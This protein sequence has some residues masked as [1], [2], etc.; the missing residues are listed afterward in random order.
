[1]TL[2][3]RITQNRRTLFLFIWI[4][5][6]VLYVPAVHAGFVS[7]FTG[8]IEQLT[9]NK[10]IDYLN[11]K[12]SQITSLYQFT[13]FS[14]WV[15]YK[16]FG[17]NAW[18]WFLLYITL[19]ALNSTLLY[20][21]SNTL[22]EKADIKNADIIALTGVMLFCFCPHLT[23][24]VVYKASYHYLQ[25]FLFIL[26]IIYWLQQFQ[27][28]GSIKY[29]WW[30]AVIFFIS[31]YSLE[32]FYLTPLFTIGMALFYW[33]VLQYDK[34]VLKRSMQYFLIPQIIL[35]LLH[36]AVFHAIHGGRLPHVSKVDYPYPFYLSKPVKYLFHILL[37]GRFFPQHI[38]DAVY[39]WSESTAGLLTFY[40]FLI[41]VWALIIVRFKSFSPKAKTAVLLFIFVCFTAVLLIPLGFPPM[42][43][44]YGDRHTYLLCAFT[45]VLLALMLSYITRRYLSIAIGGIYLLINL[46]LTIQLNLYWKRS[47]YIVNRLLATFPAADNKTVVLLDL[48]DNMKGVP[49]LYESLY[50]ALHNAT[51][52]DKI[53][54]MVYDAVSFTSFH[55]QDGAHVK[56]LNDSTIRV[57]LNQW[58]S[59]W[60]YGSLGAVSYENEA[61]RLNMTDVGHEYE[62]V[63]KRPDTQYLL[64]Y[65]AGGVWRI[66]DWNRKNVD[67]Y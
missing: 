6:F 9:Q 64:L 61:Y 38:R 15:F 13:Q 29:A 57:T 47:A 42:L 20:I 53:N 1:M 19:Q 27:E 33:R 46:C 40:S 14:T 55:M 48:P 60:L 58:G 2:I 54:N 4:V 50:K 3:K 36:V 17:L 5:L 52:P 35:F 56:V 65:Q 67:Q 28:T 43:L 18:L 59:W 30:A 8:W 37:M 7:D 31:T 51:Q 16:L 11:R 26:L 41:A 10:F 24:V 21:V 39:A 22:F 63:L 34:N 25:G 23:E 49:M 12:G 62:L 45:Y 32:I 66:V 44:V